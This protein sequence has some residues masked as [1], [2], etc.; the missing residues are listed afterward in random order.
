MPWFPAKSFKGSAVLDTNFIMPECPKEFFLTI[1]QKT[2]QLGN[3]KDMIFSFESIL[4]HISKIVNLKKGD[5]IFTGTPEGVG[6]LVKGDQIEM[7]FKGYPPK[8]LI[9]I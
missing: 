7:G 9:V 6:P 3:L 1:N 2:K 8:K 5:L 4:L